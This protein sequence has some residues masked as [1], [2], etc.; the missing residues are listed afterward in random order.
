M[1]CSVQY[2]PRH[3][4]GTLE[5]ID[6][7]LGRTERQEINHRRSI[8][9][10]KGKKQKRK[11]RRGG[12]VPRAALAATPPG[13]R[14]RAIAAH[15]AL[16]LSPPAGDF[17]PHARRRNVSPREREFELTNA[18]IIASS[19]LIS[20]ANCNYDVDSATAIAS[21]CRCCYRRH[22][23]SPLS[24]LLLATIAFTALSK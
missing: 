4:D 18:S 14:P 7:M 2:V 16:E 1:P 8:E 6:G 3:T 17:S 19:T 22:R 13:G 10:E 12:E 24:L 5:H 9:E 21:R 15:A 23:C 20:F 11:R